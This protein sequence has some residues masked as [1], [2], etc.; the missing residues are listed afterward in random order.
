MRPTLALALTFVAL[1]ARAVAQLDLR[2]WNEDGQTWLRWTDDQTFSGAESWSIYRSTAPITDVANA[3]LIAKA[4]PQDVHAAFLKAALPS[5]TWSVPD[6]DS[7]GTLAIA[8]NEA[9]F[10]YTPRAALDEYFAVVKTGSTSLSPENTYGPVA[11]ALDL[12]VPH[13]QFSGTDAGHP[14]TVYALWIDGDTDEASG[15][16]DFPVMGNASFRGCA[17]LFCA[18]EPAA[19]LPSAPMPMVAFL[20]GGDGNYWNYRP[21]KSVDHQI[22]AHVSDG[23]Y[24]T[25]DDRSWIRGAAPFAD[26]PFEF[27][28]RWFGFARTF[29]RF[30][31]PD[32]VPPDDDVVVDTTPRFLDYAFDWLISAR[33]VDSERIAVA[34]LSM[35]GRGTSIYVRC[36]P[37]RVSAATMFVP[38]IEQDDQP[39]W[40]AMYGAPGQNLA[41]PFGVGYEDLLRFDQPLVPTDLPFARIVSGTSDDKVGWIGIPGAYRAVDLQAFGWDLYWDERE[42]T[43]DAGG[44]I[45][46]HFNGSPRLQVPWLTRYRRDRSFPAIHGVDHGVQFAGTQP[47][48]G[49]DVLPAN[50]NPW[51]TWGGWFEWDDATLEDTSRSLGRDDRAALGRGLRER[52]LSPRTSRARPSR[53]GAAGLPRGARRSL[54]VDAR[55]RRDGNAAALRLRHGRSG[56]C[57]ECREPGLHDR[58]AQARAE[59][60]VDLRRLECALNVAGS[61]TE[62]LLRRRASGSSRS[63]DSR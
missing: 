57:G 21:S 26:A 6:P 34:G 43:N 50:G 27:R 44:W 18:F 40:D 2:V 36:R 33:G 22:N 56:R 25:F 11:Q 24:V 37:E 10:V 13:A 14:Y 61:R 63:S 5:A 23:L 60:R 28:S 54:P 30:E 52:Q 4:Y 7:S 19:G 51:G 3:E 41:T 46:A 42:H 47:D 45:G 20:H 53:C 38:P 16:P 12:V 32:L 58:S 35:G 9:L 59:P 62:L 29:D 39:G 55:R 1:S 15:R 48:P 8:A 17:R 49:G 31:S